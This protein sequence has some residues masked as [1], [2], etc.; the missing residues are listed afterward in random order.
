MKDN[1]SHLLFMKS[2]MPSI[3]AIISGA[4]LIVNPELGIALFLTSIIGSVILTP[5]RLAMFLP[6][7]SE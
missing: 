1:F 5:T 4:F 2:N 6:K 3:G 7:K